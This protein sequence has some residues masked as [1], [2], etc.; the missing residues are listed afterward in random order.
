MSVNG[1]RG[2]AA[3]AGEA[4]HPLW[5]VWHASSAGAGTEAGAGGAE[6]APGA[7]TTAGTVTAAAGQSMGFAASGGNAGNWSHG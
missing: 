4:A 6:A 2:E 1:T 7:G 5:N 3:A